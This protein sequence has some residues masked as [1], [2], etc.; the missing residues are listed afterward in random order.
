MNRRITESFESSESLNRRIIESY[1]ML[2]KNCMTRHPIMLPSSAS[3]VTAQQI[4]AENN[5]R[6]LPIVGDGKRLEGLVT[7][8]RLHVKPDTLGSLSIWEISQY[9]ST[10]T[11]S[12]VMLKATEVFTITA[13]RTI[14]RAAQYMAEHKVGCLLVMEDEDIVVGIITEHDVLRSYQLMLGLPS[15]GIRVTVRMPNRPGEFARLMA[16]LAEQ[17]WGVMG[18]GTFPAPR[19]PGYYDVVVKV[20]NASIEQVRDVLEQIEEQEVLDIRKAS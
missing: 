1:P 6:H 19:S 14:E 12:D 13:N 2:V 16:I 4:L 15:E 9:L 8:Q 18:I 5:I 10:L 3:V 20:P 11:V 17:E 7:R